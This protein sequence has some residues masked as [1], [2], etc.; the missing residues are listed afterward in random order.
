MSYEENYSLTQSN[1]EAVT[2]RKSMNAYFKEGSLRM[3][4][5]ET[6]R[7]GKGEK[8]GER[9]NRGT[10]RGKNFGENIRKLIKNGGS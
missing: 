1:A 3:G 9:K 4:R 10:M 5:R 2:Y 6:Q 7:G 8:A